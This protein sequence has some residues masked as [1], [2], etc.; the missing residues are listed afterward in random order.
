[1][2]TN[3]NNNK[4]IISPQEFLKILQ[5]LQNEEQMSLYGVGNPSRNKKFLSI[6]EYSRQA[7]KNMLDK[8]GIEHDSENE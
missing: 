8:L 4:Q 1:M 7:V 3:N 6:E 5:I 2:T